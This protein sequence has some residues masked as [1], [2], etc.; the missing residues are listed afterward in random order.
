MVS[1]PH[2]A[3]LPEPLAGRETWLQGFEMIKRAFPDL[4]AHVD[5]IVAAGD[6]VAVR[7]NFTG[8][9]AGDFQGVP[10]TGRAIHYVSHEFYRLV[11]SVVGE[12]WICSDMAPPLPTARLKPLHHRL[13]A[14]VSYEGGPPG[15]WQTASDILPI[16]IVAGSLFP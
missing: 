10:T 6:R 1:I 11:D 16:E 2:Y 13:S 4:E 9:H 12:E 14:A 15:R 5:D 3:E 7:V 8:T